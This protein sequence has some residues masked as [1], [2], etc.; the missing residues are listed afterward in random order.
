MAI[1]SSNCRRMFLYSLSTSLVVFLDF[2]VQVWNSASLL[3][4]VVHCP[5]LTHAQTMSVF[6]V[7]F[8]QP[9][10]FPSVVRTVSF[11]IWSRLVTRNNLLSHVISATGILRSS[12]FLRHQHS[13]TYNTIGTMKVS[14]N[15][16]L[17]VFEIFFKVK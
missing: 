1:T 10:S 13:E 11:F 15:F 9:M 14:Y 6:A 7:L 8:C 2:F 12:S 5:S 17:V 3:L 16:T 4:A